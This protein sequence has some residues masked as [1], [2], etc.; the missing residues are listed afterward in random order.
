ML[1]DTDRIFTNLYNDES[2][3]IDSAIL[4]EIGT[5]QKK[6]YLKEKI[7]LLMKSKLQN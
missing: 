1:K 2:W 6:Y 4:R 5:I 3:K 7:G